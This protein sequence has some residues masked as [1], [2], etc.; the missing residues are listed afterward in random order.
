MAISYNL[1]LIIMKKL[2][3]FFVVAAMALLTGCEG[4]IDKECKFNFTILNQTN[5]NVAIVQN[6][7]AEDVIIPGKKQTISYRVLNCASNS[8]SPK[9]LFQEDEIMRVFRTDIIGQ[10]K[11]GGDVM[12]ETIFQRKYWNFTAKGSNIAVYELTITDK[13]IETI[14]KEQ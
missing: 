9:D 8:S 2:L 14:K 1:N 12:P 5:Q 4:E 11:V 7:I 13:L 10:I 6:G 3:L